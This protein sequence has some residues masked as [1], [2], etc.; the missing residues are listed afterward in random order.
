MATQSQSGQSGPQYTHGH[1]ASVIK[2]HSW[3][4]AANSLGYLLPRLQATDRILDIGCGPGTIT[5]DLAADHVPQGSVVGLD[6]SE[7]V[8]AQA[9]KTAKERG[10]PN[11]EF[12]AGDAYHLSYEDGSFDVVACHQVLQHVNDPVG[13]LKEMKRVCKRGGIVAARESD[14]DGF[15]WYPQSDGLDEWRRVYR[16]VARG[17]G[18]E[19]N[20]GRMTHV[21][22]KQAGFTNI[23]CSSSSWCYSTKEEKQWWSG[24][25]AERV[26]VDGSALGKTALE[27]GV[28]KGK[29]DLEN[30]AK[31]WREW[32]AHEDGWFQ[33][34]SGEV[35]CI[36]E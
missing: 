36:N 22:A 7:S 9:D 11:I 35:I 28:V 19:P 24:T 17:N 6:A 8:I 34:P 1:H 14:Y 2:S 31:A 30:L 3:R 18:G 21:W 13:L 5:C 29:E 15:V 33:V 27:K 23:K 32:G 10:I 4:T 25:W 20:A 16:T 26:S 12:V